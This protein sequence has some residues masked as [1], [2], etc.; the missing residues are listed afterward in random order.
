MGDLWTFPSAGDEKPPKSRRGSATTPAAV[1]P[2]AAIAELPATRAE[3]LPH[4]SAP[5]VV[6]RLRPRQLN[7]HV[8]DDELAQVRERAKLATNGDVSEFVR[9][10]C[11]GG[12]L[13]TNTGSNAIA[14]LVRIAR[15]FKERYPEDRAFTARMVAAI[16]EAGV[17]LHS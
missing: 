13:H 11:L 1:Q 8:T 15:E 14:L 17:A 12:R 4:D 9:R 2:D 16:E 10:R 6:R 7:V 5:K 3:A